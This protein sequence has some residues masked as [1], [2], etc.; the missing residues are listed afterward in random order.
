MYINHTKSRSNEELL[1]KIFFIKDNL[2]DRLVDVLYDRCVVIGKGEKM[3]K[4]TNIIT[5]HNINDVISF[6]QMCFEIVH[7]LIE[8]P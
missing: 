1:K 8:I 2:P 5:K 3:I 6:I 4:L 7:R